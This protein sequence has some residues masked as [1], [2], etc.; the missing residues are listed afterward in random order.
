MESTNP[1]RPTPGTTTD[2][3]AASD[4]RSPDKPT[5]RQLIHWATGDRD[6]EAKALADAAAGSV[7]RDEAKRAVQAAHGD[8]PSDKAPEDSEVAKPADLDS[9][10]PTD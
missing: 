6:A 8:I 5:I 1:Q 7:S 2:D 3:E 10:R 4:T 9:P